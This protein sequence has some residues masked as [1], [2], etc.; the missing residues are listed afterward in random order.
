[1]YDT[2]EDFDDY[3][4]NN[5]GGVFNPHLPAVIPPVHMPVAVLGWRLMVPHWGLIAAA[6][7]AWGIGIVTAMLWPFQSTPGTVMR[8]SAPGYAGSAADPSITPPPTT[9]H[10]TTT[11]STA[12]PS[13]TSPSTISPPIV[14]T[15]VASAPTTVSYGAVCRADFLAPQLVMSGPPT[16]LPAGAPASLGLTVDNA[17]EGALLVICGFPAKSLFSA[18]RSID[19]ATWTIPVSYVADVT[20]LPPQGFVGPAKL[21][22][23]LL[24]TELIL[25]DRRSLQLQ[26]LP[27]TLGEQAMLPTA[28]VNEQLKKGKGLKAAGNLVGARAIFL[29]LALGG[30]SLAAFLL[31]ETYDPISLAK[32]QLLPPQS[33]AE[34]AR[35]WYRRAGSREANARLERLANW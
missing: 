32:H 15:G 23:A 21:V 10:P 27:Q 9:N 30:D 31:A 6:A 4:K 3:K 35:L 22:V 19:E 11:R 14:T 25:T 17:P 24:S 8:P 7:L 16:V 29:E 18:G 26:W 33:D 1:M 20:L 12:S 28:E 34:R 5:R 2:G 13:T